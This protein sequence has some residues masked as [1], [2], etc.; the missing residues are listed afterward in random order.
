MKWTISS[1]MLSC[2]SLMVLVALRGAV[3]SE[4]ESSALVQERAVASLRPQQAPRKTAA[5]AV[6][7]LRTL[8]GGPEAIAAAVK[9]GARMPSPDLTL[10]ATPTGKFKVTLDLGNLQVG[11]N[12]VDFEQA[13]VLRDSSV[14]LK[15][16]FPREY[17]MKILFN[18]PRSGF[19]LLW[20]EGRIP[21]NQAVAA[22]VRS[23]AGLPYV[24]LQSW[25]YG[26]NMSNQPVAKVFPAVIG[27]PSSTYPM[28]FFLSSGEFLFD[29]VTLEEL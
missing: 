19:Y 8:P 16:F 28:E 11:N 18:A 21:P 1:V 4:A 23:T 17:L 14:R 10:K 7:I 25:V 12:W 6:A 24:T 29:R 13:D 15:K 2:C 5:E 9:G 22:S 3:A 20:I 26:K 27:R